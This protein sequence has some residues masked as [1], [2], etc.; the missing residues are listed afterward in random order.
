M[1]KILTALASVFVLASCSKDVTELPPETQTG[2]NTFG[3]KVNG[4]FWIPQGFGSL[5]ANDILEARMSG[6][7][8]IINARNFSDSPTETEFEI[9]L[10][11][12]NSTGTYLLN[13]T[14][15]HPS[16]DVS[17]AY[18]VKRKLTPENE[19]LTSAANTGVVNITKLDTVNWIVSGTF[20]FDMMNI[21]NTPDPVAVTEGRF[22]LKVQ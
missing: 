1:K 6:N 21:Y 15:I 3:A 8:I 12:V 5:P 17:Y 14:V 11:G 2:A 16:S 7:T 22:D 20:H 9:R 13:S 19:W 18:Y 10:A 4:Q